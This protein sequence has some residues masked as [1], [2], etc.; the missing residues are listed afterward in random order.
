MVEDAV[1]AGS[2]LID[3]VGGKDVSFR[4][5]RI[6][7]VIVDVLV[8]AE[9]IRFR[10]RRRTAGDEVCGLIVAEAGKDRVLAEK[11]W[12]RRMSKCLRSVSSRAS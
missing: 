12:S 8:A 10:P 5:N 11:L 7:S 3:G 6:A 4:Y 9:G 2:E 1:V